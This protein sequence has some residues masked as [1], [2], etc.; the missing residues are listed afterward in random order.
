L[1]EPVK[2]TGKNYKNPLNLLFHK[3]NSYAKVFIRIFVLPAIPLSS[4]HAPGKK[5]HPHESITSHGNFFAE[6]N[7]P[8]KNGVTALI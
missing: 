1:P 5:K 2:I 7:N 6:K 8:I 3:K 4:C